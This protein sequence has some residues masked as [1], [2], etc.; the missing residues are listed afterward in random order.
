MTV[1]TCSHLPDPSSPRPMISTQRSLNPQA[2]FSIRVRG[3][4]VAPPLAYL[5][6]RT[7]TY[8]S[9]SGYLAILILFVHWA[10]VAFGVRDMTCLSRCDL[11]DD[12]FHSL[13]FMP[14]QRCHRERYHRAT[15][16][17]SL[18]GEEPD[19][20]VLIDISA[21]AVPSRSLWLS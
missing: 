10:R 1:R 14:S 6:T 3:S 12:I 20:G 8:S 15:L 9:L 11:T 7:S 17:R 5:L 21:L 16:P 2:Y 13:A 18:L 19:P 4:I